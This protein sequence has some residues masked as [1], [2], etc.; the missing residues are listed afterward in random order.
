MAVLNVNKFKFTMPNVEAIPIPTEEEAGSAGFKS[1]WDTQVDGFGLKV[2]PSKSKTFVLRY[3]NAA[4]RERLYTIGKL[5]RFTLDQARK[6][7]KRLNGKVALDG[8][9]AAERKDVRAANT[10]DELFERYITEHL[11]PNCSE[12]AVRSGR[13]VQKLVKA[14]MGHRLV[15]EVED[16]HLNVALKPLTKGNYN[17]V[18]TYVRAAWDW[19]RKHRVVP[20]N[21]PNP[22]EFFEP[23]ASTSRAKIILA[24]EYKR[25]FAAIEAMMTERRN[26][27]GRL[28]ACLFVILTGCRPVEAVRLKREFV[29]L[30]RGK[31]LL[32][33]HKTFKR[34]G[35]PKVFYLTP[36][37]K[38]VLRRANALHE[39]R[40]APCKFVF[41]RRDNPNRKTKQKASNWLSKT[42]KYVEQRAGV[43]IDLCQFRSGLI[44]TADDAGLSKQ[45]MMDVT[46][47]M[48]P[49]TVDRH[50]RVVREKRAGENANKLTAL[51]TGKNVVDLATVRKAG[52][53]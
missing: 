9:P 25:V 35:R 20:R 3:Q 16:T 26:D 8:D 17:L 52:T 11:V 4:G 30:V 44:N 2:R 29:D 46:Q 47:H 24:D 18:G 14:D 6:Q 37:V 39:L 51:I 31:A 1:Y 5:G 38:D 45:E 36:E 41:P 32:H 34:T 23:K 43:D 33:E 27:P 21:L 7:A 10:V 15:L 53:A 22:G 42:W 13:R 50:Y 28:L 40:G 48:S 49:A 12:N 19:G